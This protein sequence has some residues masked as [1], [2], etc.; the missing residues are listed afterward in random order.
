MMGR[1]AL[2]IGARAEET[3]PHRPAR[4][5]EVAR[6]NEAVAAIAPKIAI[7]SVPEL[8]Q[9][10]ALAQILF[11]Q[12]VKQLTPFQL[13]GLAQAAASLTGA[14]GGLDP[15][16]AVRKRLG[17]DRLS[18]GAGTGGKGASLQAGKYL[19]NGVYVGAQQNSSGGTRAQVQ[20]DLT[21]HLKVDTVIGTGGAAPS[22]GITP[23]NDPGSSIGLTYQLEY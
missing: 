23:D 4:R 11:G 19:A 9:D 3:E 12:S 15:L 20:I 5:G 22:T 17:L 10:E 16:A 18:A 13:A 1:I 14:G 7:S 6:R 8:P 2:Q 21:K